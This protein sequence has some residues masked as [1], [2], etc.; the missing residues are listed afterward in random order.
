[1]KIILVPAI[2]LLVFCVSV[3]AFNVINKTDNRPLRFYEVLEEIGDLNLNFIVSTETLED[4]KTHFENLNDE[5]YKLR[6]DYINSSFFEKL[7]ENWKHN[8]IIIR[9]VSIIFFI[10]ELVISFVLDLLINAYHLFTLFYR[11]MFGVPS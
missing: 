9:I 6:E 11:L 3:G 1:M 10:I 8:S 2:I 5:T 7:F 4:L